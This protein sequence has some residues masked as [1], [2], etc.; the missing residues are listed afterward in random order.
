MQMNRLKMH[1]V[2]QNRGDNRLRLI[3]VLIVCFLLPG[4]AQCNTAKVLQDHF[5]RGKLI[6]GTEQIPPFS[7]KDVNGHWKGISIELWETLAEELKLE[8]VYKEYDLKGLLSA[9][10]NQT[11]DAATAALTI[12]TEREK[13]FDFTH[14]YHSTGLGIAV[15]KDLEV[16]W[17]SIFK[18]FFN[19]D[20]LRIV[21]GLFFLA[22]IAGSLVWFFERNTNKKQFGGRGL[23]G[24]GSGFWWSLVTMTTVGY[25]DKAPQTIGGRIVGIVWMFMALIII[26]TFTAV[27]T[28]KLT[29]TQIRPHIRG[30]EDLH[31][32]KVGSVKYSTSTSYLTANYISFKDYTTV[33]DALKGLRDGDVD[34]IVYDM[35]ILKYLAT[36]EMQGKIQVLGSIF[37]K[38]QYGIGLPSKSPFREMINQRVPAIIANKKWQ[39]VLSHYLGAKSYN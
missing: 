29:V 14:S 27:I 4:N 9:L 17:L 18:R 3:I 10:E 7:F 32:V 34:A 36:N 21:M 24:M 1:T 8:Y 39:G 25:G 30:P 33:K 11:I 20:F 22:L 16:T 12:T 15:S 26:S 19:F 28:S 2:S 31:W 23:S 35:P 37:S 5:T 38:Q 13:R 6:V